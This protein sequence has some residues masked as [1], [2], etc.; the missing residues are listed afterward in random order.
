[1]EIDTKVA[2]KLAQKYD[3]NLERIPLTTWKHE[4]NVEFRNQNQYT[5]FESVTKHNIYACAIIAKNKLL[6][7]TQRGG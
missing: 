6:N 3:I 7:T 5:N 2:R 1:M 4:L